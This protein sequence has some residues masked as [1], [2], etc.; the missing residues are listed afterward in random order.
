MGRQRKRRNE[1]ARNQ[2]KTKVDHAI[3]NKV[4]D[5]IGQ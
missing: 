1:K 3:E 4:S 2:V 5:N